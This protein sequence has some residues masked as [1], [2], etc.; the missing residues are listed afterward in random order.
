MENKNTAVKKLTG[1]LSGSA[2]PCGRPQFCLLT[3][4]GIEGLF[5]RDKALA[6]LVLDMTWQHGSMA[7]WVAV[8]GHLP[9]GLREAHWAKLS[10]W[11]I[12]IV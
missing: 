5:K 2:T 11:A 6:A 1:G 10:A 4:S 9:Q 7:H 12:F 8:S 3:T